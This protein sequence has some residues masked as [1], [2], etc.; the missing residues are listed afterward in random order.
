MDYPGDVTNTIHTLRGTF[1]SLQSC[2][3][4]SN[5]LNPTSSMKLYTSVILPRALFGCE[6]WSNVSRASMLKLKVAHRFC[7]K[8]AQGLPKLTR[9]DIA[10]GT[11]GV[12]SL[13]TY[14]N[15]RKLNFL[16]ILCKS[17][18]MFIVKFL[19][20]IRLF[21]FQCNYTKTHRHCKNLY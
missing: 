3:V 11:L 1:L 8:F 7:M 6:L 9:K 2:G 13:E 19:F 10:L 14:I 20:M 15:M 17:N 5:G 18:P 4:H 16:G 21:Q 12:S